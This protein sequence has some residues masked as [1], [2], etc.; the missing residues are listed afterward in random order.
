MIAVTAQGIVAFGASADEVEATLKKKGL[1]WND[2]YLMKVPREDEEMSILFR[3]FP[4]SLQATST[5]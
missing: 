4:Q 1:T 2:V 5:Q 3:E